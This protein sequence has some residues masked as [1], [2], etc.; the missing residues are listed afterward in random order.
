MFSKQFQCP[1]CGGSEAYRSRRRTFMEKYIFPLLVLQ[2][3]RCGNCFKRSSLSM[4]APVRERKHRS[5]I[6]EAA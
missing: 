5:E 6:R 1:D 4:F 3:V 2:P